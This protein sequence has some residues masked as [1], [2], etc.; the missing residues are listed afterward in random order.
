[1]T[2]QTLP[3]LLASSQGKSFLFL[4]REGLFT[5]EEIVR[6]LKKDGITATKY[7]EEGVVATIEH[8]S[9]NPVEDEISN[10]A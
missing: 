5:K 4:G 7:L 1:M 8:T 3:E 6:F 9:L 2:K 10:D